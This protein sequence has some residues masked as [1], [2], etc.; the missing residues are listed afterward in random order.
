MPE[1]E[2]TSP[3]TRACIVGAGSSGIAA[4][5]ELHEQGIPFD[6]FELG[7]QVGGNWVFRNVNGVSSSYKSLHINTS[8]ERMEYSDYP[9]PKSYPDFPRH[10]HIAAYFD[11]YV[12]HFGFR[13]DIHFG[14]GVEHV[15][16][17]DDGSFDVQLTDGDR[18]RLQ[19][20]ARRQ[21][22]PL[23]SGACPSRPSPAP[24]SFEGEQIH[25]HDYE[26]EAQLAGK[27]VVVLGVG[28]SG[29]DIAVDASYHAEHTYLAHRRGAHVIPKYLFGKPI[30]Q[31]GGSEKLPG[32]I[33]FAADGPDGPPRAGQDGGLRAEEARPQARPRAPDDLRAGSSTASHTGRS[34]PSRTS[35]RSARTRSAST[36]APRCTPTS[37]STAPATGSPSRSSTRSFFSAPDNRVGLYKM[38]FRARD[39]RTSTSSGS[40]SRSARSCRSPSASRS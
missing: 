3:E 10:D 13:D 21:R 1:L 7:D 5:K 19:P 32:P 11:D 28:N 22:P 36:T 38:I 6:C 35:P 39:R 8:R 16:P 9:M 4:A 18:A 37:S 34:S 12:D 2:E 20:R 33:R 29:M 26:E 23:G 17:R 24:R 30:D 25:S 15:G 27:D 40:C 14:V 31:I